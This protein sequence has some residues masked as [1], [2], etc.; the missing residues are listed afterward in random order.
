VYAKLP[1]DQRVAA[2]DEFLGLDDPS[3]LDARMDRMYAE[4][5]LDETD[6]R[7][8]LMDA[9]RETIEKDDDPFLRL[10]VALYDSDRAREEEQE[11]IVGEFQLLRPRYMSTLIDFLNAEGRAVYPDANG[12]LRVTYGTVEGYMPRDGVRFLPF[13]RLGG[14]AE[15]YTGEDPF[16]SPPRQ[17]ELIAARDHGAYR[18]GSIDS[19]PVNFLSTVDTTGGNSGSPVLDGRGELVGLLFDGT[20]DSIN[21]DWDFNE[22]TTRSIQVDIRYMLWVMERVDGAR[23][24]LKELGL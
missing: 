15:K 14:I 13:T 18:L 6:A 2:L 22:E 20:Y 12:S 23:R 11:A 3:G 21:A 17:L 10:A 16:D 9:D 8:A 1:A 7:L 5:R 4:T 24:V 19:V